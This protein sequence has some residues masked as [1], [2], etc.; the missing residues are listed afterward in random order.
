LSRLPRD[1]GSITPYGTALLALLLTLIFG[2][3]TAAH[4]ALH[5]ARLQNL[6]D[7]AVLFAH[8]RADT[9]RELRLQVERFLA[10]ADAQ[11]AS[12]EAN[13]VNQTSELQLCSVWKNP[14]TSIERPICR[15]A[16]AR[17][18]DKND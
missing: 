8:D 17:S 18:F 1:S 14:F 6:S 2:L 15:R 3:S 10:A 12:F 7:A 16:A 11:W 4:A 5:A 13:R 9:G